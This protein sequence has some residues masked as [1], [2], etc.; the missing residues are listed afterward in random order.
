MERSVVGDGELGVEVAI[1]VEI[2]VDVEVGIGIA[3][4][5]MLDARVSTGS[6]EHVCSEYAVSLE[7]QALLQWIQH[8]LGKQ[9]QVNIPHPT[10]ATPPTSS[11][12]SQSTATPPYH[13]RSPLLYRPQPVRYAKPSPEHPRSP[14]Q[15][16]RCVQQQ[17]SSGRTRTI[18]LE[19]DSLLVLQESERARESQA[20]R[21]RRSRSRRVLRVIAGQG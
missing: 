1:D 19:R 16:P 17:A 10:S 8:R 6:H 21:R 2:D 20:P 3:R 18:E 7:V 12:T 15:Q 5:R 4:S 11:Q 13:S 9:L 14:L